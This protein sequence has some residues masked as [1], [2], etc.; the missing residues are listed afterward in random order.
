MTQAQGRNA[1]AIG[2]STVVSYNQVVQPSTFVT[3]NVNVALRYQPQ[4]IT[5]TNPNGSPDIPAYNIA[6]KQCTIGP[7]SI[8]V[9]LYGQTVGGAV[10]PGGSICDGQSTGVMTLAGFRGIVVKW[11]RTFNAGAPVDIVNS[12]TTYNEIP[13]SGPG[14]YTYYAVIQNASG[15]P[16]AI[17]NSTSPI[18][19]VNPVSP[20]PTLSLGAASTGG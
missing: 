18:V 8:S 19:T 4:D 5:V 16:C 3:A 14:T 15:G 17:V 12:T 10:T 13:A 11:Q 9:S 7:S 6:V 20:L 2:A 1:P